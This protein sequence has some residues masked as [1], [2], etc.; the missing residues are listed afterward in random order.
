M[1]K[2]NTNKLMGQQAYYNVI[3]ENQGPQSLT[4]D[5]TVMLL[6]AEE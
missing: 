5:D 4:A 2:T 6:S 3:F 1:V